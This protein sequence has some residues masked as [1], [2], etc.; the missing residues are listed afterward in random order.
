MTNLLDLTK[1]VAIVTG[2]ATGIGAQAARMLSAQGAHVA[3]CHMPTQSVEATEVLSEC[4]T[5]SMTAALD[6]TD[7][8]DCRRVAS[9]VVSKWGRIDILVNCAG[10]NK[11]VDHTD[12]EGLSSE[13]FAN[14]FN[15]NVTGTYLMIR[16][17]ARAMRPAGKG[18]V[19]NI[20]SCAG[21]T[22]YGS[23]VA[24]SASKGAVNTMTKS[25]GRALAPEIRVNAVCPG[26]VATPLW[27]K[28]DQTPE[29]REIM[30]KTIA[31][32]T[33]LGLV[34]DAEIITRS[35]LYLASD[36]S[37]HLTGQLVASD[38]GSLLGVYS[39][40]FDQSN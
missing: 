11:P 2:A 33:P 38:G 24:Y 12:L 9:D 22:G 28:L 6:V 5:S 14:I 26:F 36:L 34:A 18:C 20:S 3:I 25:L 39:K 8:E 15:V 17:V 7:D 30:Y 10:I 35:I 16:A 29:E 27:D 31:D 13:D 37:A 19:V 23:S 40:S 32:D 21:E 1:H 4:N